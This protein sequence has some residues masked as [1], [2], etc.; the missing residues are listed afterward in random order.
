MTWAYAQDIPL[1]SAK[2]VLVTLANYADEDGY[3]FPS[4]QTLAR[5]TSQTDRNVRRHLELLEAAGILIRERR[6]DK[7]GHRK[8]D[9][10]HLVGYKSLPDNLSTRDEGLPDITA[11]PTGQNRQSLPDITAGLYIEGT[12]NRTTSEPPVEIPPSS[13]SLAL[14]RE[15]K[16]DIHWEAMVE[17][18][19]FRPTPKTPEHQKW[20]VAAAVF[21][22]LGLTQ[23]EMVRAADLYVQQNPG[24]AF[25]VNA[26]AG[27]AERLLRGKRPNP[28]PSITDL[29]PAQQA[30]LAYRRE[31]NDD[32][33]R[34]IH[35]QAERAESLSARTG[36]N[37]PRM[38]EA[39]SRVRHST[40]EGED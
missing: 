22:K 38:V 34:I 28:P 1:S 37:R 9:G 32:Y 29:H 33:Q 12:T 27:Q 19:G 31:D 4:Q 21:R 14:P 20:N 13:V 7:N 30:I 40:G 17:I 25:T 18:W 39:V 24:M 3:C 35:Q 5:D 2:F 10:F 6:H 23:E 36:G 26:V 11:E 16:I 15:K 8:S